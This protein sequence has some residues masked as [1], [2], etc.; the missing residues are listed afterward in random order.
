TQ[1]EAY[2]FR[3]EQLNYLGYQLFEMKRIKDAIAIL[4]LNAEAYPQSANVYDSLGEAYMDDGDKEPAIENYEKS[5]QLGPG[6]LGAIEK[7]KQLKAH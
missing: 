7:L 2:D 1:P 4:K 6:N 3:E 5:L